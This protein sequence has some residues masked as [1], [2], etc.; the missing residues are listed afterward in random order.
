MFDLGPYDSDDTPTAKEIIK[1]HPG[2]A[3]V[4][5]TLGVFR[6]IAGIALFVMFILWLAGRM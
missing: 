3:S 5:I 6:V 2:K 4:L 1:E